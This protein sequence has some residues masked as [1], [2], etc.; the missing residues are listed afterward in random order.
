MLTSSLHFIVY[1]L[2]M[3]WK[4]AE[5]IR[6]DYLRVF[7]ECLQWE[8]MKADLEK[9]VDLRGDSYDFVLGH[10]DGRGVTPTWLWRDFKAVGIVYVSQATMKG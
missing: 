2:G 7:T 1:D 9:L 8:A 4:G 3:R 6:D 5:E 10:W